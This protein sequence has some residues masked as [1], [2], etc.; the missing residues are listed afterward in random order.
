LYQLWKD[1][2]MGP[3]V[4]MGQAEVMTPPDSARPDTG[5]KQEK[6]AITP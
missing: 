2:D 3:P 1:A 6:R 5:A 4:R